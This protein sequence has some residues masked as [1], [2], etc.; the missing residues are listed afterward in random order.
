MSKFGLF[1]FVF[2]LVLVFCLGSYTLSPCP[3]LG[4]IALYPMWCAY[5]IFKEDT[6]VKSR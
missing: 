5:T 2:E 3:W 4:I 1:C 6:R